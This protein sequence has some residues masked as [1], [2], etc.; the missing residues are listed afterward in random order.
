TRRGRLC[1]S[2]SPRA[3]SMEKGTSMK[4][5]DARRKLSA[6]LDRAVPEAYERAVLGHLDECRACRAELEALARTDRALAR[7]LAPAPPGGSFEGFWARGSVK[8]ETH[9]PELADV[10]TLARQTL[11]RHAEKSAPDVPEELLAS[12]PAT[13][14]QVVLP[15]AARPKRRSTAL[16]VLGTVVAAGSAAALFLLT[17]PTAPPPPTPTAAPQPPAPPPPSLS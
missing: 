3:L 5:Y 13:L 9:S 7:A 12:T 8:L 10:R 4:C 11:E 17:R 16:F 14:S 15:V 2:G 1:A 6:L